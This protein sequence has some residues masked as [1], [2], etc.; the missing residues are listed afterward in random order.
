MKRFAFAA[1]LLLILC[2]LSTMQAQDFLLKERTAVELDLGMWGGAK[3]SN[4]IGITGIRSEAK[5]GGFAGGIQIAHWLDE[6]AAVTIGASMLAAEAT[7]TVG[8]TGPTNRASSV[9]PLLIGIRYAF[10]DPAPDA[11]LRPY[12]SAAV[13]TYIGMEAKSTA[14]SQEAHTENAFGGRLGVGIDLFLGSFFKL[15]V[16]AG[17]HLMTDFEVPVGARSNYNGGQ[18]AFGLGF[19]F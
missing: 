6:R 10:P 18:F 2:S 11:R 19:V 4:S 5:T 7:S 16:S 13:G 8:W 3:A 15:G 17:Y 12:F 9:V 14:L 1:S